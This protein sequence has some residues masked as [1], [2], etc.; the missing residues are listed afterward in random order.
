VTSPESC[1]SK[2]QSSHSAM[3]PRNGSAH[4]SSRMVH[5]VLNVW[6]SVMEEGKETDPGC[7]SPS[8]LSSIRASL[9]TCAKRCSYF[10]LTTIGLVCFKYSR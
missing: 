5:V 3:S 10:A 2:P 6:E 7:S 9:I 4:G 1:N 8:L